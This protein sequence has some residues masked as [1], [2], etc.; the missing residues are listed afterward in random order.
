[1]DTALTP[2]LAGLRE[3]GYVEGRNLVVERRYGEGRPERLAGLAA[4]LVS[5]NPDIVVA[6]GGDVVPA[7][8][9]ATTR[10]PVVF[11]TSSDPVRAGLVAS[12]NYP[13][14]NLTGVTLLAADL[15]AKRL[16]LLVEVAPRV[17]RVAFLFNPAHE[18]NDLAETQRAATAFKLD[19][20]P[21]AVRRPEDLDVSFRA[22]V[23]AHADALVVVASRLTSLTASQIMKF[24]ADNRLPL[25]SGWGPWVKSGGLLTYG[26]NLGESARRMAYYVDKILKGTKPADLPVEQPTKVE[27]VINLKTAQ[28]LGL[29]VPETLLTQAD[30]LIQ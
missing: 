23:E 5:N 17:R 3:L 21:L 13:G 14:G 1:M 9:G 19:L 16:E 12:L 7:A 20:V 10:I 18:D 22:A 28:A 27:L 11:I 25:V 15:A 29:T 6:I 2:F 26:P 4:E 8:K 24:A 30:E